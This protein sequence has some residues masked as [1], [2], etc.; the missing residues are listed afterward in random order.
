MTD[1]N[2]EGQRTWSSLRAVAGLG[3]LLLTACAALPLHASD[4]NPL[5]I[6]IVESSG[7]S[8]F[9]P[10][11]RRIVIRSQPMRLFIRIRN[12]SES[13]LIIRSNP[14]QAYALELKDQA[15]VTVLVKKKTGPGGKT[16]DDIRVNL[17]A[18]GDTVIPIEIHR[19]TW[20][21]VPTLVPGKDSQF[22]A[23]VVY[24]TADGRH[25]YSEPYTLIFSI[26]Q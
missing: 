23:R 11:G 22:T 10:A 16:D 19:D 14:E 20:E 5:A 25:V 7:D 26:R 12:T 3:A 6:T 4:L 1:A 13:A 15:G 8:Y 21:G 2:G 24:E 17:S 9:E 18:G